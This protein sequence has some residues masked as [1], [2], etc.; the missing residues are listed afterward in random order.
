MNDLCWSS[1]LRLFVAVGNSGTLLNSPD[2]ITWSIIT[3]SLPSTRNWNVI[4][5]IDDLNIFFTA[6]N[7]TTGS[8]PEFAY[9]FDGRVFISV[10]IPNINYAF[11]YGVAYS[12]KHKKIILSSITGGTVAKDRILTTQVHNYSFININP[13]QSII[14]NLTIN[15]RSKE[16]SN[17]NNSYYATIRE[18]LPLVKNTKMINDML[19]QWINPISVPG[20]VATWGSI[21]YS[22]TLERFVTVSN[23]STQILYSNDGG[24]NWLLSTNLSAIRTFYRVVWANDSFFAMAVNTTFLY[25]SSSGIDWTEINLNQTGNWRD[26]IWVGD[27]YIICNSENGNQILQSTNG[28]NWSSTNIIQPG[29][30]TNNIAQYA[31]AYSSELNI[32][33]TA[34]A[35]AEYQCSYSLDKGLTWFGIQYT[36]GSMRDVCWAKELNLFVAV[37]DAGRIFYSENGINWTAGTGLPSNRDWY[38]VLWIPELHIFIAGSNT[39]GDPEMVYSFD[40]KSFNNQIIISSNHT[41]QTAISYSPQHGTIVWA[42]S[43]G[44]QNINRIAI[45]KPSNRFLT[46]KNVFN[47]PFNNISDKA[48]WN[49]NRRC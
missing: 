49:I 48:N 24:Y 22:E 19:T 5:W 33:V 4:K 29:N 39:S 46:S 38:K 20:T 45:T 28:T 27:K 7:N 41:I 35:R 2:G 37:G 25:R 1:A 32:I 14:R 21:A 6:S 42:S 15:E 26:L 34:N 43:T 23:D 40:G 13:S 16:V 18:A 12:S 30:I 47:H 36:N 8:E 44:A 11:I 10:N 17:F 31:F 3:N 9:S